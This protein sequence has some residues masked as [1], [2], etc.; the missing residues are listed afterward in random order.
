MIIG[1]KEFGFEI[2]KAKDHDTEFKMFIN[3]KNILEFKFN[4]ESRTTT[5]NIDDVII[6]LHSKVL[7]FTNDDIKFPIE[8]EGTSAAEK[9]NNARDFDTDDEDE[10]DKYYDALNDWVYDHSWQHE[11]QG[12]Y[13]ADV[14][15]RKVENNIE[16]SWDN[17]ELYDDVEYTDLTGYKLIDIDTFTKIIIQLFDDYNNM[18]N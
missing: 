9:A 10:F 6:F 17:R 11:C 4:G 12:G 15:F 5:W 13:I 7:V 16:V 14:I 1:S 2:N 18:W 8:I 3:K